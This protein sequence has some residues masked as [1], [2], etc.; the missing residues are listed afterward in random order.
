MHALS[1]SAIILDT[2][3]KSTLLLAIAWGAALVLKKRSAATQHMVRTFA[4]AALL[5]RRHHKMVA[6]GWGVMLFGVLVAIVVSRITV[7]AGEAT[8]PVWPG[9]P[10]AFAATGLLLAAA[11]PAHRA[12][13]SD[14]PSP[15]IVTRE[16]SPR[17]A[18][19]RPGRPTSSSSSLTTRRPPWP[20]T[21]P[22][23]SAWSPSRAR[24]SPAPT[25]TSRCAPQ[26]AAAAA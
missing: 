10:L 8:V 12:C 5:L 23:S 24:P 6:I 16:R 20:P 11:H 14:S 25:T 26:A 21:C 2:L 13:A 4:L 3:L 18:P 17:R 15:G 7:H 9:V 19:P 1:S 22:T